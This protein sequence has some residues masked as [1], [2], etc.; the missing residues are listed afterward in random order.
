MLRRGISKP[1][2]WSAKN[3]SPITTRISPKMIVPVLPGSSR[4]IWT[5]G[6]GAEYAFGHFSVGLEYDYADLDL[7]RHR[8]SCNCPSGLGG[9]TPIAEADIVVQSVTA[10]LNYHLGR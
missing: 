10:R 4:R 9:G 7:D 6:G 5:V 3:H 2:V 8:T 1:R